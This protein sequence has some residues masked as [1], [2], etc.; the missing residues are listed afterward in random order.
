[1]PEKWNP[2]Y[3]AYAAAHGWSPEAMMIKDR[4]EWPGGE[5]TGFILWIQQHVRA[6]NRAYGRQ[7][8]D[9]IPHAETAEFDSWLASLSMKEVRDV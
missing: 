4:A 2:R 8:P 9:H 3:V 5:M 7:E 1:M 6:W